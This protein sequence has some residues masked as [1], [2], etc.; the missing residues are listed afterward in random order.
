MQVKYLISHIKQFLLWSSSQ[1]K[2]IY[3]FVMLTFWHNIGAVFKNLCGFLY[4]VHALVL[5][6]PIWCKC[7]NN[8]SY[9]VLKA[10]LADQLTKQ[11]L[12]L[13]PDSF[14]CTHL[15]I[16]YP[17]TTFEKQFTMLPSQFFFLNLKRYCSPILIPYQYEK[18]LFNSFHLNISSSKIVKW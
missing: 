17:F 11:C 12:S 5:E 16:I 8:L 18:V 3:F 1:Y 7:Q 14:S 4:G 13:L 10:V 6:K 15:S 9:K 2:L